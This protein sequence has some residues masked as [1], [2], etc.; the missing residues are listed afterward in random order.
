MATFGPHI[1][2]KNARQNPNTLAASET[3]RKPETNGPIGRPPAASAP[4]GSLSLAAFPHPRTGKLIA[5]TRTHAPKADRRKIMP[6]RTVVLQGT[7]AVPLTGNALSATATAN[8][9]THSPSSGMHRRLL[10]RE[11][12]PSPRPRTRVRQA[13]LSYIA[14]ALFREDTSHDRVN[15]AFRTTS[16]QTAAPSRVAS[17]KP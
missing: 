11:H 10:L 6:A 4:P 1:D 2:Q 9:G 13:P 3:T 15:T 8:T 17:R 7:M 12:R 14:T 5:V 16:P